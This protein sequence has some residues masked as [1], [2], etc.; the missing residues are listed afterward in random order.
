M[1]KQIIVLLL[2]KYWSLAASNLTKQI[3]HFV[4]FHSSPIKIS[5]VA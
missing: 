5:S 4:Q 3:I 1:I 2:T